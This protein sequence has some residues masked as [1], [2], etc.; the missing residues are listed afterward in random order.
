VLLASALEMARLANDAL[1]RAGL[2]EVVLVGAARRGVELVDEVAMLARGPVEPGRL[3]K[4]L[5]GAAACTS[6]ETAGDTVRMAFDGGGPAS[7]QIV[8]RGRFVEALVRRT[9]SARHVRWL[10]SL[11]S[12]AGG[13]GAVCSRARTEGDVYTAL[14]V[15]FAPPELREGATRRVPELVGEVRG[16]FHVHTTWSDGAATIVDMARAAR[17]A[18]FAYVGI[19]EHSQ[20]AHY[21]GG[22]DARRLR[23]QGRAVAQARREVP[24]VDLLHG[25]EVDVMSDGTLD[26]DD[27]TLGALDFVIASVHA[28]LDMSSARM[29]ARLVR[30]VSHP[31]VTIL[32]HPTGRLLL[33]RAGYAFDVEAVAT[34]A[35]ANDTF[36]EINANPQ[37]LDLGEDLVRRAAARGAR[38]AIDPDAHT[39]R[40]VRDTA[41]GVSVARRAGLAPTQVLNARGPREAIAYLARRRLAG[42]RALSLA[43]G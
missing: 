38:F 16:I 5:A 39:P 9:G 26:L 43:E 8:P 3:A 28:D 12:P 7:V 2:G 11:A 23:Q 34:A 33:G 24:G 13:L 14:G 22:L 42:K 29:T 32:G 37:R 18:G 35:A 31:L 1:V 17:E 30:A 15:P 36:L 19:T 25:V 27:A 20:A 4:V 21:A 10:E 40:G 6:V 41:L